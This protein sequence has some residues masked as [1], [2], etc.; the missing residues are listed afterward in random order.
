MKIWSDGAADA[1]QGEECG[2]Y[3]HGGATSEAVAHDAG[4]SHTAD[5][6]DERAAYVPALLHHVKMELCYHV[7]DGARDDRCVV[8]EEQAAQGCHDGEEKHVT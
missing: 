8:S 7:V 6:A 4:Y 1:G 3:E 5:R 2:G